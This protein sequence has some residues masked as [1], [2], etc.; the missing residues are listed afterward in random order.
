MC[1]TKMQVKKIFLTHIT[2][3]CDKQ[4]TKYVSQI[5]RLPFLVSK[6]LVLQRLKCILVKSL[7]KKG[8]LKPNLTDYSVNSSVLSF[9][10]YISHP[11]FYLVRGSRL[12]VCESH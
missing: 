5:F 7:K 12:L 11:S 1:S 4:P 3:S 9:W 10:A 8:D 6:A 2:F